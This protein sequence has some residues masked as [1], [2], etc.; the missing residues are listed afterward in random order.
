MWQAADSLKGCILVW[1]RVLCETFNV[2]IWTS[3]ASPAPQ[4]SKHRHSQ[5]R[6]SL[7]RVGAQHLS[8]GRVCCTAR[9]LSLLAEVPYNCELCHDTHDY[10]WNF[11]E[12][13]FRYGRRLGR[14]V[15][16][17]LE[18]RHPTGFRP[19]RAPA[20]RPISDVE[21]SLERPLRCEFI[22]QCACCGVVFQTVPTQPRAQ[23]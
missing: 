5:T 4:G 6:G 16:I 19:I 7:T 11:E 17:R 14:A 1:V 15:E 18:G 3:P 12:M 2:R 20:L 22:L 23:A 21:S 9:A 13:P 8:K 10:D